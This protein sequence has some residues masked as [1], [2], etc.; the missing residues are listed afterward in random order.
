MFYHAVTILSS[1]SKAWDSPARSSLSF[2]RQSLASYR[3]ST[4]AK[5]EI[6]EQL[7]LFPFVPYAFS[8]SLSIAYREMRYNKLPMGRSRARI[9]FQH[10]CDILSELADIFESAAKMAEMG[11]STLKEMDRVHSV[12][13]V[14]EQRK[15]Q[16]EYDTDTCTRVSTHH[17]IGQGMFWKAISLSKSL[18]K[19]KILETMFRPR[20]IRVKTSRRNCWAWTNHYLSQ[21]QKWICSASLIRHL[22]WMPSMRYFGETWI[23]PSPHSINRVSCD[24][25]QRPQDPI[26]TTYSISSLGFTQSKLESGWRN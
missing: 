7:V 9:Q 1:R 5:S 14:S 3:V 11:T 10:S 13:A 19:S 20:Q 12:V 25:N 18:T 23:L 6:R 4:T 21:L 2:F 17:N 16:P 22:T 26:I 8:L 24:M 15:L